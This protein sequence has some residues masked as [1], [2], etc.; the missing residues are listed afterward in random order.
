MNPC[1]NGVRIN[2]VEWIKTHDLEKFSVAPEKND[3]GAVGIPSDKAISPTA[4]YSWAD[5]V[6]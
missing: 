5:Q 3:I 6:W 1:N 4:Q 2:S